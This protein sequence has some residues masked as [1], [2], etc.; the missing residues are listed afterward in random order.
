LLVPCHRCSSDLLLV[1]DASRSECEYIWCFIF[2]LFSGTFTLG[3]GKVWMIHTSY[4]YIYIRMQISVYI[5]IF[6]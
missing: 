5:C 6:I 3:I 4:I 2:L 1:S